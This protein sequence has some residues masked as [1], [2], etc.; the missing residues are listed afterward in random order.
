MGPSEARLPR[1]LPNERKSKIVHFPGAGSHNKRHPNTYFE[2]YAFSKS[3]LAHPSMV[4]KFTEN[5]SNA[6]INEK[7]WQNIDLLR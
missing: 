2:P 6:F 7:K 4:S 5:I 3:D 1:V